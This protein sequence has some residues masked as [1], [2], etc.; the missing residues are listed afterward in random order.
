MDTAPSPP[1][2]KPVTLTVELS[3]T[4]TDR[5]N[6]L[7][8]RTETY[9]LGH[10]PSY[11]PFSFCCYR[12]LLLGAPG[13]IVR[14][15][16]QPGRQGL[17]AEPLG[18]QRLRGE[19]AVEWRYFCNRTALTFRLH[20]AAGSSWRRLFGFRH[21][22]IKGRKGSPG[23][24]PGWLHYWPEEVILDPATKAPPTFA[25]VA[26]FERKSQLLAEGEAPTRAQAWS[27]WLWLLLHATFYADSR[28]GSL[29][30]W[31]RHYGV[32]SWRHT[33]MKAGR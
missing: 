13:A 3:N 27:T 8:N 15:T 7:R 20:S 18:P 2:R 1:A 22:D 33:L 5:G 19:E 4:R 29:S 26:D 24:A 25:D 30:P 17:L 31:D 16:L 12:A 9:V 28:T 10:S 11:D 21:S 6:R 32:Q 14:A 23:G